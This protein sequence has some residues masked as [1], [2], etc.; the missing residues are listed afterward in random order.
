MHWSAAVSVRTS[1]RTCYFQPL[2][3]IAAGGAPQNENC[4]SAPMHVFPREISFEQREM[5]QP[6]ASIV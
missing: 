6:D 4:S 2:A 1:R 3:A 5:I